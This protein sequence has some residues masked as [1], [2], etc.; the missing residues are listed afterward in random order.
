MV[1]IHGD[2][3]LGGAEA[4]WRVVE[5]HLNADAARKD[6][7]EMAFYLRRAVSLGISLDEAQQGALAGE[8]LRQA[9]VEW[10]GG[11]L[12][13]DGCV[14]GIPCHAAQMLFFDPRT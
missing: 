13:S 2:H 6:N 5:H 11:A 1:P 12:G 8:D 7:E 10:P 14:Y 4:A 3:E 9:G